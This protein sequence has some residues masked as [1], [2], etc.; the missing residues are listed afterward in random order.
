MKEKPR[1]LIIDDNA[2]MCETLA[3][4]LEEKGYEVVTT[5]TASEAIRMAQKSFFNIALIDINLPDKTGIELLRRFRTIYPSRINIMITA[6]A[7]LKNAVDALNLGANA[8]ILKPIDFTGLDQIMKE[9]LGKQQK[10]LKTTDERLAELMKNRQHTQALENP[11]KIG[12]NE[13]AEKK[14]SELVCMEDRKV[15]SE[16]DPTA[17]VAT[18]YAYLDRLL[19]GGLPLGYAAVLTSPSCDERDL[20]VRSFLD[21]GAK[22]GE[23][24]FYVTI[25]AALAKAFAEK[26]ESNF[27]LFVCNPQAN[28]IVKSAHNVFKLKGVENLMDIT[29]ALTSTIRELDHSLKGPRRICIGLVSDV[30]LEHHAVQTRRWLAGLIPELRSQGFTMLAVIDP[31]MHPPQDV[32]AVSDLFEGEIN[33]YGKETE[34]GFGKYLKIKRMSNHKHLE[35]ELLLEREGQM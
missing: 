14:E 32:R 33:I 18:G 9:C 5:K 28:A 26:F 31:E 15:A 4:T 24:T 8:Y 3:D 30:L 16:Y 34:K 27:Y 11:Q 22:S 23:V 20:L 13:Y 21:T 19:C 25:D 35:N 12:A 10:T 17:H 2:N 29:I 6:S 1:V 7:M